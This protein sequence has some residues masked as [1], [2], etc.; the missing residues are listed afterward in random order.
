MVINMNIIDVASKINLDR[1]DLFSYNDEY[2]KIINFKN[3]NT[4]R[5]LILVTSINPTTCNINSI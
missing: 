1:K 5:K 3:N 4:L 2:A